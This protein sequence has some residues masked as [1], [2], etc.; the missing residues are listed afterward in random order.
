MFRFND[1]YFSKVNC[2]NSRDG[3]SCELVNCIYDHK[4]IN[5]KRSSNEAE[6]SSSSDNK[7]INVESDVLIITPR[8]IQLDISRAERVANINEII[9]QIKN[10][11]TPKKDG[12][13]QEFQIANNAKSVEEYST[14][15]ANFLHKEVPKDPEFILP[16]HIPVSPATIPVRKQNILELVKVIQLMQPSLATPKLKAIEEEYNVAIK[17]TNNTYSQSIKRKAYELKNPHKFKPKQKEL[18]NDDFYDNLLPLV[19]S[20]QTLTKYGY[21]M[22]VPEDSEP[23]DTRTCRRCNKEFDLKDQLIPIHCAFHSGKSQKRQRDRV[24]SCCGALVNDNETVPCTSY[25]HHVFYWDTPGEMNYFLPF[26]Y[27]RDL[28]P[29]NP[30]ALKALGIDCEM[31]FTTKGFEL[32]RITAMD[33][34]SG[35]EVLDLLVKP[36][37]EVVDLNSR[38][39]G[40]SEIKPE[41]IEF[42]ELI[43][44]LGEVMDYNTILIGHG[45]END[46]NSMRLI[47]HKVVDTAILYP[48]LKTSPTFRYSLKHLV[49]TYL[50]KTIQ[51]GQHDSGEDALAAIDI[52]KYFIKKDLT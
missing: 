43:K 9:A 24:Y 49:F 31:G 30:N 46:L 4:Q 17:S 16:R 26:K 7:R 34:F 52:V 27:T 1:Q 3:K 48:K 12:I 47:H 40:I 20:D 36:K 42:E 28:F 35:Q 6:I 10:S 15:M 18:T 44:V 14:K 41:A 25:K 29:T 22:E 38:W 39:S 5:R 50:G 11:N 2:P 21:I 37:G 8:A 23:S 33:Y 13:N 19:I 45:L 51:T 32:L